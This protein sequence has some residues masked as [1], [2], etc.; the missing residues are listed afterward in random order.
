MAR[1]TPL[2]EASK[3]MLDGIHEMALWLDYDSMSPSLVRAWGAVATANAELM[4][5]LA[6]ETGKKVDWPNGKILCW[7]DK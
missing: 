7:D 6:H 2:Q 4:S 3:K 1:K 5:A